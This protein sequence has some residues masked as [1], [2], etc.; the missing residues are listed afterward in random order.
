M[1]EPVSQALIDQRKID[2]LFNRDIKPDDHNSPRAAQNSQQLHR[3][4]LYDE[5]ESRQIVTEHLQGVLLNDR[6]ITKGFI[7][8]FVDSQTGELIEIEIEVRDSLLPGPSGKFV[9]IHSS[10]EIISYRTRRF[11]SAIL[12]G[13]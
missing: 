9:Q 8:R 6:N 13:R 4:G 3:L 2:Y 5:L 7:N 1:P 12:Y 10:W 11:I